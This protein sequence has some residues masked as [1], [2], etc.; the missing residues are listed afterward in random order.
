MFCFSSAPQWDEFLDST[1]EDKTRSRNSTL[2]GNLALIRNALLKIARDNH[3][4]YQSICL[5]VREDLFNLSL[6]FARNTGQQQPIA[7]R[8]FHTTPV[9]FPGDSVRQGRE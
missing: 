5:E 2:V 7:E 1:L 8:C 6:L 3:D 9:A 4:F